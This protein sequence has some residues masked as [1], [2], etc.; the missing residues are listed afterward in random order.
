MNEERRFQ[1]SD[2]SSSPDP[3]Q[4]TQKQDEW[5]S[6]RREES[7]SLFASS[8]ARRR[9]AAATVDIAF[10]EPW[11]CAEPRAEPP[12]T[13]TQRLDDALREITERGQL[14]A[15]RVRLVVELCLAH[16]AVRRACCVGDPELT[17]C[18]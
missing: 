3:T 10:A 4:T 13:P 9:A 2:D 18:S 17:R 16:A 14:S 12:L 15:S 1:T 7:K 8:T 5:R 6:R 11:R